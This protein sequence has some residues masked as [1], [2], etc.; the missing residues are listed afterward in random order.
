MMDTIYNILT[1]QSL[2]LSLLA[3]V[4]TFGTVAYAQ[5]DFDEESGDVFKAPKKKAVVDNNTLITIQ[6][7]VVDK[8]SQKPVA[9]VRVQTLLD[10]RYTGMTNAEGKFTIKIPDYAT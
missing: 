6:G 1:R 9:G 4:L 8:V 7:T 3:L 5:D 2:R 10:E